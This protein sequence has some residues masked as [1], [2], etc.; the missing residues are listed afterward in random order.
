MKKVSVSGAM[1]LFLTVFFFLPATARKQ[2]QERID[3]ILAV[4]GKQKLPDSNTVD[5]F[6]TVSFESYGINPVKGI[7]YGEKGIHLAEQ[8]HYNKGLILCLISVGVSYWAKNDYP[9][10]LEYLY[11]ALSLSEE[12]H[13]IS[14]Q[15]RSAGN[16]GNVY[17][18]LADY[19]RALSFYNKALNIALKIHDTLGIARKLGNIGTV[20]KEIS[21]FPRA[22]TYYTE[23]LRYYKYAGEKRGQAVSLENMGWVYQEQKKYTLALEYFDKALIP[24]HEIGENRWIMFCYGNKGVSY[25]L[26][27]TDKSAANRNFLEH[28]SPAEKEKLFSLAKENL[29]KAIEAGSKTEALKEL[30]QYYEKLAQVFKQMNQWEKAYVA[31]DSGF[32][33]RDS[34]IKL[35]RRDEIARFEAKRSIDL[36][37]KELQLNNAKL[38]AANIQRI[39]LMVGFILLCIIIFLIYRSQRKTEEL[40]LNMLPAKIAERLKNKEKRIADLFDNAAVV[41]IVIVD[42]TVF[43]KDKEPGY[44]IGVLTDFFNQMDRLSEKYGMEK[45]KTI[46]DCFMSVS[47]LP[48]PSHD[49]VERAAKFAI[50]SRDLMRNYKT[51]DGHDIRVRIGIDAGKVVAGVIGERRFSYDLWGDVVNTASRMES[52]GIPGEIQITANVE[53]RLRGK[54][55]MTERGDVEVKGKGLM[56][57]WLLVECHE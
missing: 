14:G 13:S 6:Q 11:R 18:E 44:L 35:D 22:L 20:Y 24:A 5:L 16:L 52:L 3:S 26:M 17:A 19:P 31:L 15:S 37:E 38:V 56:H 8:L 40:L 43:Y 7:Y 45:I 50:E 21:D 51:S 10:A 30:Y 53:K 34:S 36:K 9:K 39:A 29:E 1:I 23:S 33:I 46:G 42:F 32:V 12:T 4:I 25:Y 48:E 49:S 2:G 27:A 28:L 54:F 41:F 47:G 57:T 55:I